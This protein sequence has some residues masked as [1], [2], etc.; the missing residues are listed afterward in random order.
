MWYVNQN[1]ACVMG[2]RGLRWIRAV[3]GLFALPK[4][5]P[6]LA[7]SQYAAMSSQ[8]PLLY[9]ILIVNALAL[10]VTHR[11]GAPVILVYGVPAVFCAACGFRSVSWLRKRGRVVTGQQALRRL[12]GTM[13]LVALLGAGFT[14]WSLSLFPYGGAYGQCQVEFYMSI[15]VIGCIFCLMHLRGA[16]LLLTVIVIGPFTVFFVRT[17][18]IELVAMAVNMLLVT[19]GVLVVMQRHYRDFTALIISR[20]ALIGR[21]METQLLSDENL[22]LANLDSLTSLPNRRRFFAELDRALG[23]AEGQGKRLAVAVLDLDRFKGVNDVY[24]HSAGDRLLT[25]VGLRLKRITSGRVFIARLGGDEFGAIL[26]DI[27]DEADILAFGAAVKA[28]LSG[29]CV[30]GDRLSPIS[31][32]IGIATYPEAAGSAADLFERADYALYHGKQ[33][34][35]GEVVVFS[36]EHETVIRRAAIVE[37]AFRTADL[38]AELWMAFQPIFDVRRSRVVAFEALARWNSAELGAV[39]PDVFIPVAERS[40][41]M[42]RVT[43]ILF[44]KALAAARGWPESV[45][46]CF[47]LSAHDLI[48]SQ[49]MERLRAMIARGEVAARRIEF[50]VTETALLQ[51]FE[52]AAASL[53]ALHEMGARIS[54]DDFGTGYSSLGYVHRLKLDKIKID[55][56]FVVDVDRTATA[57]GIVR[58]IVGLCQNLGLDCVVEGVETASQLQVLAG[59]GCNLIQGYYFSRPVTGDKVGE[60]IARFEPEGMA[61]AR[62]VG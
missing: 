43:G 35:R 39:A 18:Q 40:Q 9:F 46:L 6:E 4:A 34:A 22:R 12:R 54:L 52:L 8:I 28:L 37:Q 29:P 13:V 58:T 31:C 27:A 49:T 30:V 55:R 19:F 48:A 5:D 10:A 42:A 20:R 44:A 60:V 24:G 3:A 50:E 2:G 15:T 57:P 41:M 23:E 16:A 62:P 53:Q 56:S 32:S 61:A 47:N 45:G 36:G 26:S 33:V 59:L 21:Q 51:N 17:G 25:Q 38:E 14:L 11:R 1:A 7:Q